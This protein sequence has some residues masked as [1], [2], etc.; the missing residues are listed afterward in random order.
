MTRDVLPPTQLIRHVWVAVSDR[1]TLRQVGIT[2]CIHAMVAGVNRPHHSNNAAF[3]HPHHS[4]IA[5]TTAASCDQW[6]RGTAVETPWT[7]RRLSV[8]THH[9]HAHIASSWP[10][11]SVSTWTCQQ[12][13]RH[14]LGH[15]TTTLCPPRCQAPSTGHIQP[16][17]LLAA[18][19]TF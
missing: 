18:H 3:H 19:H 7:R 14:T 5:H 11:P 15:P 12:C 8:S 4:N 2:L 1:Q 6:S 16:L 17:L 9:H 10:G 13:T